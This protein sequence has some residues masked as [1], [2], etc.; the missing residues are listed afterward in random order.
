MKTQYEKN[1]T[2]VFD[3]TQRLQYIKNQT[4]EMALAAVSQEGCALKYVLDQTNEIALAAVTQDAYAI[5]YVKEQTPEIALAAVT[6]YGELLYL[7]ERQNAEIVL[8]AVSNYGCALKYVKDQTLE[9]ILAAVNQDGEALQYVDKQTTEITIAAVSKDGYAIQYAKERGDEIILASWHR[10]G[11][12]LLNFS[13]IKNLTDV[14]NF[15]ISKNVP[16]DNVHKKLSKTPFQLAANYFSKD[17][18]LVLGNHGANI[19]IKTKDSYRNVLSEMINN[20]ENHDDIDKA[21]ATISVLLE[22]G[23]SP[24]EQD[25]DGCTALTLA[26]D[27]PE[28]LAVLKAFQ[29]KKLINTNITESQQLGYRTKNIF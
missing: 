21:I 17:A 9:V 4:S 16:V 6:G 24:T 12:D 23:I 27:K 14:I 20:F 26:K 15:L 11:D 10:S 8:A 5:N 3:N 13:A 7:V 29:I 22:M 25:K 18:L 1:A 2:L 28:I 19:H